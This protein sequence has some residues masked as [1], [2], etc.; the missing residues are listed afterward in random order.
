MGLDDD[1]IV[2]ANVGGPRQLMR[3]WPIASVVLPL[4]KY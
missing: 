2:F 1:A 3:V 4:W